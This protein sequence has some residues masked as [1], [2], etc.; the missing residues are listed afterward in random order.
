MVSGYLCCRLD[1]GD[2][3][4]TE[5]VKPKVKLSMVLKLVSLVGLLELN[6]FWEEL[7]LA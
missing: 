7:F 2:D 5:E 4:K 1:N 3:V 6:H